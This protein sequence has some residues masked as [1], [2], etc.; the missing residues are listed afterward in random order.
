MR[1]SLDYH[2]AYRYEKPVG[3]SLHV[4]RLFPR[5]DHYVSVG[6][7]AFSA[8]GADVQ[9]RRDLFDNPVA[10]LFFPNPTDVMELRLRLELEIVERNPFHFLLAPHAVDMPFQYSPQESRA[11]AAY[12]ERAGG[13]LAWPTALAP[14][15]EKVPTV[16]KLVEMNAW[17]HSAIVYKRR[18]TG[19]PM[20]PSETLAAR[21]GSCRD[22]AVLFADVLRSWG[23]AARL[24]SGYLW[25]PATEQSAAENAL[26]A[27]VEAYLPG[28][29]WT[30]FDPTNGVLADHHRIAAAVGIRHEEIAP[31]EGTYF[32]DRQISNTLQTRLEILPQ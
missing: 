31:I 1:L 12:M 2:A 15:T 27:W 19:P 25:E 6:K 13:I 3:L 23:I 30:G 10:V 16:Q 8:A 14:T 28:A 22:M 5:C 20:S 29:G 9:L 24:V 11:L 21:C 32:A 7:R 26:H 18:E 4:V 17:I